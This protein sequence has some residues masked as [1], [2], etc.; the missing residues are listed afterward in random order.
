MSTSANATD[1][2]P[3][4]DPW[5]SRPARIEA[6]EQEIP[7]VA[8]LRLRLQPEANAVPYRFRPGQFNM[9]YVPGCGEVAIS[10][11]GPDNFHDGPGDPP[12]GLVHTIRTVGRVT[13]AIQQLRVGDTLGVRGPFGTPWPMDEAE[14]GDVLVVAG[15]LGLAPLRPVVERLV[16]HRSRFGR[17]VLFYG[18]RSPD[19][20]LYERLFDTWRGAGVEVLCTV[21]RAEPDWS[22]AVGTVSLLVDRCSLVPGQQTS[23]FACGPEIMMHFAARSGLKLGLPPTSIWLSMERNMQCAFGMCGHCQWGSH[24]VCRDGPVLRY[25]V[26]EPW[27]HVRDM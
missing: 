17:A 19:L 23:M 13:Q 8:T 2:L 5:R 7:D 9:L 22:G 4:H 16:A 14:G 21:D 1:V 3:G 20:L 11:S 24:F 26:V 15:G 12:E 25:D 18:A 27:L 10:M 6:I